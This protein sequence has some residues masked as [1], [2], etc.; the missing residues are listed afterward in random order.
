MS[1]QDGMRADWANKDFYK[2]LGV[3]KEASEA[4]I[5]KAYR[6]LAR[7]NHPDSNPGDTAKHEKFKA[8]AE[9]YDVLGDAEKRKKYDEM[10]SLFGSG[11][12]P[13][14]FGGGTGG[15]GGFD[16]NDLLRD[17]AGSG[18]GGFGDM[19]GDLFGGGRGRGRGKPRPTRGADVETTATIGFTDAMDGVTISLRLTSDSACPECKGS[20]GKPGTKPHVCPECEGAGFVVQSMGGAFSI[21][22]TCPVCGGRQLV[23]DEP[24]PSCQGSGRGVSARSIQARIPAGVRDGQKIRLRGKGG[25]GEN[26][27]TAGDLFVTVKVTP[28]RLFGRKDDNLTLDV[29]ISFDEAALGGEIKIPTLGGAP[30]T[31][32]IPAGTPNGRTFRVRGKGAQRKDGTYGDLLATVEVQ[33][34]AVLD[35]GAREAVEAYR[36]ATSGKPLRAGLFEGAS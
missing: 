20:G 3:A 6:K 27:G 11:R 30:V 29:P 22:E 17:R 4:D 34:P 16:I 19:F 7:A 35:Q 24:C 25:A 18:G 15:G 13:G 32:K 31:L 1:T 26:G 14:G 28:H 33:V 36:A 2:E 23:Y 21:N 9:A 5:K 12:F 8:V 10:R